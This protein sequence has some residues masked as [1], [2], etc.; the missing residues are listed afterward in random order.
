MTDEEFERV[1]STHSMI[2]DLLAQLRELTGLS[3][4]QRLLVLERLSYVHGQLLPGALHTDADREEYAQLRAKLIERA[5]ATR[6]E[7]QALRAT[8]INS[9]GGSA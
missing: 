9:E 8:P 1:E 3:G 7:N 4:L 2:I 5:E 6:A